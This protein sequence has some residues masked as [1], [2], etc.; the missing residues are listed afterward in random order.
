MGFFQ[1][2][3]QGGIFQSCW[4]FT[5]TARGGECITGTGGEP[6]PRGTCARTQASRVCSHVTKGGAA[7]SRCAAARGQDRG[8]GR[9]RPTRRAC[10]RCGKLQH[11]ACA[12]RCAAQRCSCNTH[13][14]E[15]SRPAQARRLRAGARRATRARR[16]CGARCASKAAP[17]PG[18]TSAPSASNLSS[19]TLACESQRDRPGGPAGPGGLAGG[20]RRAFLCRNLGG[21]IG[22]TGMSCILMM[23][24]SAPLLYCAPCARR[25][26]RAPQPLASLLPSFRLAA[27]PCGQRSAT[28]AASLELD[29]NSGILP[30]N[31]AQAGGAVAGR[32]ADAI[33]RCV[34]RG[35]QLGFRPVEHVRSLTR[36]RCAL[37]C[38]LRTGGCEGARPTCCAGV[39]LM[40]VGAPGCAGSVLGCAALM[41]LATILSNAA[42]V[43]FAVAS[44]SSASGRSR[45]CAPAASP[46]S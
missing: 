46:R 41:R 39:Y 24:W 20:N 14:S 22:S 45:L 19:P 34:H 32:S 40:Y 30:I 42:C 11:A 16:V 15:L 3:M 17:G 21:S 29:F 18:G 27:D 8:Q 7:A 12:L 25:P 10:S 4:S 13:P 9:S 36:A 37:A 43:S 2:E 38:A 6:G 31:G 26:T 28:Q 23:R 33:A 44:A 5:L 1:L 35:S